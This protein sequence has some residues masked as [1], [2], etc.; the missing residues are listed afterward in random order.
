MDQY[1]KCE[2]V[3]YSLFNGNWIDAPEQAKEDPRNE[4]AI[5]PNMKYP[6][7]FKEFMA[8]DGDWDLY[9]SHSMA[10]E[11]LT[12]ITFEQVCDIFKKRQDIEKKKQAAK[13]ETLRVK[14]QK[15]LEKRFEERKVE[16]HVVD[17]T[18]I[19]DMMAIF[20]DM[21]G[22]SAQDEDSMKEEI[23]HDFEELQEILGDIDYDELAAI[24]SINPGLF[25]IIV[26]KILNFLRFL[27]KVPIKNDDGE[28]T[29]TMD[30]YQKVVE[31]LSVNCKTEDGKIP[32]WVQ[33]IKY[34]FDMGKNLE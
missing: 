1:K 6:A 34:V 10:F 23:M 2:G 19:D 28:I 17:T 26:Q 27:S 24:K 32:G 30:L 13:L 12:M 3:N 21:G 33:W 25:V 11:D 31:T 8:Y 5:D 7:E 4:Y 16:Q 14:W 20:H 29:H 18:N 9:G 15:E 22:V